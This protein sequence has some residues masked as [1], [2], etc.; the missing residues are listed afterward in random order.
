MGTSYQCCRIVCL[1]LNLAISNPSLNTVCYHASLGSTVRQF[2]GDDRRL[3]ARGN[4]E[5]HLVMPLSLL[6]I[7]SLWSKRGLVSDHVNVLFL[8]FSR[9]LLSLQSKIIISLI[10]AR[11]LIDCSDGEVL[12]NQNSNEESRIVQPYAIFLEVPFTFFTLFLW[13]RVS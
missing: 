4:H 9:F 8:C 3:S 7:C 6:Q 5:F 13:P 1:S 12:R 2:R 11:A 10:F